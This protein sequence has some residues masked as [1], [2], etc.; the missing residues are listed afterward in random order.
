MN[1]NTAIKSAKNMPVYD[2]NLV[3][4]IK[5]TEAFEKFE[6]MCKKRLDAGWMAKSEREDRMRS[7]NMQYDAIRRPKNFP[8]KDSSSLNIPTTRAIV[9]AIHSRVIQAFKGTTPYFRIEAEDAEQDGEDASSIEKLIQWQVKVLMSIVD[10]WDEGLRYGLKTGDFVF[11]L[12]WLRT[13][14]PVRDIEPATDKNGKPVLNA[15]GQVQMNLVKQ[16]KLWDDRPN[17]KVIHMLDWVMYPAAV[18][19][20]DAAQ[21]CGY[22]FWATKNDLA[23]GVRDKMYDPKL[24]K[25]LLDA[26]PPTPS[27]H[28]ETQGNDPSVDDQIGVYGDNL[29]EGKDGAFEMQKF[30][31]QYDYDGDGVEEDCVFVSEKTTGK[32]IS[33]KAFPYWHGRR[34]FIHYSPYPRDRSFWSYAVPEIIADLH[35]ERNAIRNQRV[36]VGTLLL[37][38]MLVVGKGSRVDVGT[39]VWRPGGVIKADNVDQ[40]KPLSMSAVTQNAFA[41]EN[42]AKEM[43][44][45][46]TGISAY[47]NGQSPSRSR[48][49]GEI[50]S[51]IQ[52][53]NVKIDVVI[54]RLHRSNTELVQQIMELNYQYLPQDTRV[55][56]QEGGA[57]VFATITRDMLMHRYRISAQGNTLNSNKELQV[58]MAETLYQISTT[59]PLIQTDM[60]RLWA[61]LNFYIQQ[62][63]I[64]DV[65]PF[66]G[67]EAQA[68]QLQ[69]LHDNAPKPSLL[70]KINMSGKMDEVASLALLMRSMPEIAPYLTQ[71]YQLYRA[72]AVDTAMVAS[73]VGH[74]ATHAALGTSGGMFVPDNPARPTPFPQE[75]ENNAQMGQ[76]GVA[77]AQ[78]TPGGLPQGGQ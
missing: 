3:D 60:C 57:P 39:H 76:I 55:M 41:E 54:D 34:N 75:G 35:A 1:K 12:D 58:Q 51:V 33:A 48:T 40:V 52:E 74:A 7:W 37:S 14:R 11:E 59:S 30:I 36:D 4:L 61:V 38:P 44:E 49:L 65:T 70:D 13:Y 18:P 27:Q 26:T 17:I 32:I 23:V 9:D 69:A 8:W 21:V 45:E 47:A 24:V 50:S 42:A 29:V 6:A 5:D 16:D 28:S 72:T 68:K 64:T 73:T 77:M 22:R 10:K 63:G 19:N 67:T 53:G 20:I 56:F 71:A 62:T 2:D 15:S 31:A 78:G 66:I 25:R 43:A 46:A